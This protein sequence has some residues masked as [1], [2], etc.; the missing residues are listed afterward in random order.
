M[1][2]SM[3]QI[4]QAALLCL[5]CVQAQKIY[6]DNQRAPIKDSDVVSQAFQDV[7]GTELLSPAFTT[8]D[9]LPPGWSNGK[10]GL[11]TGE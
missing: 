3:F 6:G 7:E 4:A 9:S 11:Q 10:Q 8:P 5:S 1:D 2:Y